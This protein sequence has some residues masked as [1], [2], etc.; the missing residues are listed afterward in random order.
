MI[1]GQER[2]LRSQECGKSGSVRVI[3]YFLSKRAP[4]FL[5]EIFAKGE[6]ANLAKAERNSLAKVAGLIA[7]AFGG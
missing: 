2:R 6:K 3:Y 7:K 4:I 5:L 1:T